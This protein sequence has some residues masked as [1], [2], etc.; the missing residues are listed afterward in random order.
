MKSQEGLYLQF[1]ILQI[2]FEYFFSYVVTHAAIVTQMT[3][4]GLVL[5][6]LSPRE[7]GYVASWRNADCFYYIRS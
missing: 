7:L 5:V 3:R 1:R 4:L 6:L 2:T